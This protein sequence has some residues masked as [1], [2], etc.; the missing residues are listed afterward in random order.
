MTTV[1]VYTY[2]EPDLSLPPSCLPGCGPAH[3]E[4]YS[5]ASSEGMG[6][7]NTV[8][9]IGVNLGTGAEVYESTDQDADPREHKFRSL[10]SSDNSVTITQ[11]A[12]EIDFAVD[13]GGGGGGGSTPNGAQV[14]RNSNLDSGPGGWY[15][16]FFST[17]ERDDNNY[18]DVSA[19]SRF[20]IPT[21]GWYTV[22]LQASFDTD[23]LQSGIAIVKNAAADSLSAQIA[24]QLTKTNGGG[25]RYTASCVHYFTASDYV[26]FAYYTSSWVYLITPIRAAIHRLS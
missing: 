25:A 22:S 5:C 24:C 19:S 18:W 3:V 15:E 6:F 13:L 4:I 11:L 17:E 23:N 26:R 20:T 16:I 1:T 9:Y 14:S 12:N 21:T 10:I 2:P 8:V 7:I